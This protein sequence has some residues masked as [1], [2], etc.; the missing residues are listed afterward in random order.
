MRIVGP[1]PDQRQ[2]FLITILSILA[3]SIATNLAWGSHHNRVGHSSSGLSISTVGPNSGPVAGGTTVIISGSSFSQSA[4]VVFGGVPATSVAVVSSTEL[5]AVTPAHA[6]G[7][8]TVA[9]NEGYHHQYQSA[10]FTGGFTY[11]GTT[12]TNLSISGAS[13]AK[14]STGGGTVVSITG[15][16]FQAGAA[17]TFGSSRSTAVT[18]ASSSQINAMSPPES[19]GTVP[20]TVTDPNAQSASLPSGF[21]YTSGPVVSSISP[22]SGPVMGGTTVKILGSGFQSGA[23]VTFGGTASTSVTLVSSTVIQAVAPASSAGTISIGVTNADSQSAT[24]ASAFTYFHTVTLSWS[25][26]SSSVSG[27]NVY[28]STTSG[29][30][31]TRVNSNLVSSMLFSDNAVHEG[32]TYF[33]VTTAIS[34]SNTE[35]G[36]SNQARAIVPSP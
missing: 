13:P 22:N 3:F 20:I 7:T 16:G 26:G 36:Y 23:S 2:F 32:Q 12:S 9:V 31:Y 21:T 11:T 4:S 35:S 8:V 25:C 27:F 5:K 18:V 1:D 33:Y 30:P 10:T 34:G 28:R 24:L 19:S 17:V 14:G 29:G 15:K 6:S